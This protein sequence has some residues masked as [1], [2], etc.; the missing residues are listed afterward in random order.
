MVR[1]TLLTLASICHV[2][3]A[4]QVDTV[5]DWHFDE[6][7]GQVV[8]DCMGPGNDGQLGSTL[9]EDGSDPAWIDG[10][11]GSAL[12]FDGIDDYVAITNS[13]PLEPSTLTVE[14]WTRA[15]S[16]GT[17]DYLVGK[18]VD[19]CRASSYSL[20]T[21]SNGGLHFY[22]WSVTDGVSFAPSVSAAI[23]NDRW[24]HVAG[25]YDGE[26][27]RLYV[28]GAEIGTGAGAQ[29]NI[30]YG[31]PT[32]DRLHI[33]ASPRATCHSLT[34]FSG[35]ID[36][37]RIWNRALSASEIAAR[38]Q[39]APDNECRVEACTADLDSDGSV[40]IM[41]FLALLAAWGPNPDHPADL[42]DD[43]YVGASDMQELFATWGPCP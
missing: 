42:D 26:T 19:H 40:S 7:E 12:R 9:S 43:G 31:L 28:D 22:I 30:R 41:D 39:E 23:W 15:S 10:V 24:H 36:E 8:A 4:Y 35:D 33:G 38:A 17:Y 1:C 18:G 16:P 6:S 2:T 14:L 25:T 5:I 21:G 13:R 11:F 27:V 29:G 37:V 20:Y 3:L 32:D 34:Y